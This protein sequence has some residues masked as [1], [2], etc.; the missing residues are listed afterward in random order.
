VE[1]GRRGAN[2]ISGR[3]DKELARFTEMGLL[4]MT[5]SVQ[6]RTEERVL[7]ERRSP[8]VYVTDLLKASSSA[9]AP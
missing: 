3:G 1:Q 5:T 4:R 9:F 7:D 8:V 2:L 6:Q